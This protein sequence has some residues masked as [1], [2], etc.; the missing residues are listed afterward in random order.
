MADD[1]DLPEEIPEGTEPEEEPDA[2][3]YSARDRDLLG[4]RDGRAKIRLKL[5][6]LFSAVHQGFQDQ[7]T[8]ADEIDD[9]WDCYNCIINGNQ[10]YNGIAQ[11]YWPIIHDAI[12]ARATRFV[13]QLFPASGRYVEVVAADGSTPSDIIGLLEHY[14]RQR[15]FKTQVLKPLCRNGDIEGHYNLY[16]DWAALKRQL[17]SRETHGPRVDLGGMEVEAEGE[18]IEDIKEEDIVEG[19]P[20]FEVLHD[21]DV[22]V[23]PATADSIEEA[24]EAGGSVTIVRRWT[25]AKIDQMAEAGMIRKDESK[26]LKDSMGRISSENKDLEKSLA[27][28][29]GVRKKGGGEATVWETWHKLPLGKKGAHDED[30]TPRLCRIFFGPHR[31]QLGV[32]RNPHWNDRCP[33]LSCAVEKMSGVF[34]G[35]SLIAPVATIQYEANDAVNE[36]ADAATLSAG[37]VITRDPEKYNGPLVYNVGAV[38][39][40]PPDA[41]K[42]LTFPDLTPRAV[43]RVQMAIAQIFQTLGVNPSMLPQQTRSSKPNQAQVA[44]EQQVDLLTTA[45]AVSVLEEGICTPAMAWCI[46]L[47]YQFRD[48]E[49]TVRAFGDMGV[50]AELQ[51]VAPLQNRTGFSFIWR[52]GEQVKQ[53]AMMQQQGTGWV[54]VLRGLRQELAAEGYQLHLGP[55]VEAGTQNVFGSFLGSKVL[56]DQRHQLTQKQEDENIQL[57]EGFDV[58]VHPLDNDAEHLKALMPWLQQTGDMHGT[59]RVHAQAHMTSM[60]LKNQAAMMKAQAQQ[61]MKPPG[62]G[63]PGQPQPGASPG[64]PHAMKGPPGAIHPDRAAMSGIVQMPRRM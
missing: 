35:P 10:Y 30:G 13:N 4:R 24:L 56:I 11:I 57:G 19:S 15:K 36:G 25:K 28:H 23:L 40:I 7:S 63:G 6:E 8:R 21:S 42:L 49:L 64:Q 62:P 60:Q 41:L 45:E 54:N 33:L 26:L 47:D 14:I 5:D 9:F 46:D 1:T 31:A 55:L 3:T 2:R 32:K 39:D 53:S 51:Q 58:P 34:K 12:N 43:T 59:G 27:E 16:V 37:P 22:L 48:T 38:W 44:Q 20:V 52:G 50:K 61:G 18:D 29:V 17:V